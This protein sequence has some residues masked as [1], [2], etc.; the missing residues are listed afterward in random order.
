MITIQLKKNAELYNW[1]APNAA[2]T[3]DQAK[4]RFNNN[5]NGPNVSSSI[6][7]KRYRLYEMGIGNKDREPEMIYIC[8]N[9]MKSKE[10]ILR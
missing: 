3:V 1:F 2:Y 10:P 9:R 4:S 8:N 5:W 7:W 6:V